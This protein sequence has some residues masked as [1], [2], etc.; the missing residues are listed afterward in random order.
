M[1]QVGFFNDARSV[2][3]LQM[4]EKTQLWGVPVDM[5]TDN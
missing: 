2:I 1:E 3:R 5:S 4:K